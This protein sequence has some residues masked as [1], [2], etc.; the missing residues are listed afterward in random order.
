MNLFILLHILRRN[1][2]SFTRKCDNSC[3]FLR[4]V[5]HSS[6]EVLFYWWSAER[7]YN[8][9]LLNFLIFFSSS[10]LWL[11][12]IALNA[13]QLS[14]WISQVHLKRMSKSSCLIHWPMLSRFSR[15]WLC[16][17][18]DYSLPGSS[19]PGI[20]QARIL[21]WSCHFLLLIFIGL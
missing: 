19:V 21:E 10:I 13:F 18:M 8:E 3:K 2:E 15:V 6:E 12:Q 14:W 16:N 11:W 17:P 20:L 5:L 1:N 7:V 4:D 9:L